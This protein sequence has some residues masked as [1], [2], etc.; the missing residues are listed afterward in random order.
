MNC[1]VGADLYAAIT[2]DASVIV[3]YDG[4]VCVMYGPGGAEFPACA[5][6][7]AFRR[8]DVEAGIFWL[9]AVAV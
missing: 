2:P 7:L 6:H 8:R 5:A 1:A 4:L 9:N 3:K